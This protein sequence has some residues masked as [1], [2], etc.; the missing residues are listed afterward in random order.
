[1]QPRLIARLRAREAAMSPFGKASWLLLLALEA[2]V[3]VT[4]QRGFHVAVTREQARSSFVEDGFWP[5]DRVL[6]T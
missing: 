2:E 1:M 4:L 5:I 3:G 6:D